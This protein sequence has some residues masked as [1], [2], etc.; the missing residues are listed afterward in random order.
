MYG[1]IKGFAMRYLLT[2]LFL[3]VFC[4]SANAQKKTNSLLLGRVDLG[5]SL[6]AQC[7]LEKLLTKKQVGKH[8]NRNARRRLPKNASKKQKFEHVTPAA[9]CI[10]QFA[11][12][13][14]RY[15]HYTKKA[16]VR[17]R[18]AIQKNFK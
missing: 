2:V 16:R 15:A 13:E 1:F 9:F 17:L 4:A 11:P 6:A 5:P 7:N 14:F 12:N 3:L 18:K 8:L 10:V